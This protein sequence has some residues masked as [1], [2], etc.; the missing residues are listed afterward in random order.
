MLR[1]GS[2]LLG[3]NFLFLLVLTALLVAVESGQAILFEQVGRALLFRFILLFKEVLGLDALAVEAD[4][5]EGTAT[6]DGNQIGRYLLVGGVGYLVRK[7][8]GLEEVVGVVERFELN[9]A[10]GEAFL[11]LDVAVNLVVEAA[12][13]LGAL[14][15]QLLGIERDVL[16]TGRTG[17]YRYKALHPGG[18]AEFAAARTDAAYATGLLTGTDLLHL[19]AHA[20]HFGQHLD[21]LAEIYALIGNVV[22]DGLVAIAL[23]L[24]V[25]NLHL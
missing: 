7:D 15:S 6:A 5:F 13:Q 21:E 9:L 19:D 8:V 24:Y 12:L 11:G 4:D 3:V 1:V 20:E 2:A 17:R 25:T 22:E 10:R 14:A 16:E 23:V 18:A